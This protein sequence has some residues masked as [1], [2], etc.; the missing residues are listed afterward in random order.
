MRRRDFLRCLPVPLAGLATACRD[1]VSR[2]VA[3]V[4]SGVPSLY[5]ECCRAGALAAANNYAAVVRWESPSRPDPAASQRAI[6]GALVAGQPDAIVICPADPADLA[7][8][9]QQASQSG[10]AVGLIDTPCETAYAVCVRSDIA[11]AGR[12]AARY[13]AAK[14]PEGGRAAIVV[15]AGDQSDLSEDAL[16]DELGGMP[17]P[18]SVAERP[19]NF[20]D[21]I[22]ALRQADALLR[23]S[24]NI[25]GVFCAAERTSIALARASRGIGKTPPIVGYGSDFALQQALRDGAIDALVV[26]DAFQVGY[27]ALEAIVGPSRDA[28]TAGLDIEIPP[29]L[30]TR[31]NLDSQETRA[32]LDAAFRRAD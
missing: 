6:L 21:E 10:I 14:I 9:L 30:I 12:L 31:D 16:I 23:A 3:F 1:A 32:F 19:L 15:T 29:R 27:S 20:A 5:W 13:L 24:A 11:E 22:A 25:Q 4:P 17:K 7:P 26:P 18:V 28:P 8:L 2:R